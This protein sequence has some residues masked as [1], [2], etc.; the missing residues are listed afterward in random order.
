[1]GDFEKKVKN[2]FRGRFVR[3]RTETE[4]VFEYR[5][6]FGLGGTEHYV[7][8]LVNEQKA[9]A[10]GL[11]TPAIVNSIKGDHYNKITGL[12]HDKLVGV[13]NVEAV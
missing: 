5:T 9:A 7:S 12:L 3:S 10:D 2:P 8:T 6:Y 4:G 1:M 11:D 13:L